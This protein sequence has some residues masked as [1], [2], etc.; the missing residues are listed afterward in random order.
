MQANS[1]GSFINRQLYLPYEC[2]STNNASVIDSEDIVLVSPEI[3]QSLETRKLDVLQQKLKQY[4]SQTKTFQLEKVELLK[5]RVRARSVPCINY[6]EKMIQGHGSSTKGV[7]TYEDTRSETSDTE[8]SEIQKLNDFQVVTNKRKR[9]TSPSTNHNAI[10]QKMEPTPTSNK[11]HVLGEVNTSDAD[12]PNKES[13]KQNIPPFILYFVT[14]MPPL[15]KLIESCIDKNSYLIQ[16]MNG[17]KVKVQVSTI[18]NYKLLKS[19]FDA[20]NVARHTYS[21]EEEKKHRVVLKNMHHSTSV[22]DI[23][24]ELQNLGH[25]VTNIMNV[26]NRQTKEKKNLFF[27]DIKRNDNNNEIFKIKKFLNS[28]VIFEEPHKKRQLVQCKRCQC[29]GH[30]RNQC[31]RPFRCVKCAGNHDYRSCLKHKE[32]GKPATCVLCKGNHPANYKGCTVYQEILNRRMPIR[33]GVGLQANSKQN[34]SPSVRSIPNISSELKTKT[35]S[36]NYPAMHLPSTSKNGGSQTTYA[37][38]LRGNQPTFAQA[39]VGNQNIQNTAK[40]SIQPEIPGL[41]FIITAMQSMIQN[42]QEMIVKL[43]SEISLLRE[44]LTKVLQNKNGG[45]F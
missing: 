38:A 39:L 45:A 3:Q 25:E 14:A 15:I 26:T 20:N 35:S 30:T 13:I 33:N 34:S 5:Q 44:Q 21:L 41:N 24:K 9:L 40:A 16:V 28:V 18:D 23:I 1:G 12:A 32:D 29:Y 42:Q 2:N 37:Q 4:V 22:D 19:V 7:K 31:T 8:T 10:K 27:I 6:E 11:F 36:Q 17:N 43:T